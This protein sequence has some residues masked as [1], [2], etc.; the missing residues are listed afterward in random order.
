MIQGFFLDN[1]TDNIAVQVI[2]FV[3][4]YLTKREAAQVRNAIKR[5]YSIVEME[6]EL[7]EEFLVYDNDFGLWNLERRI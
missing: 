3:G 2:D 6:D 7:F 1:E 5:R 4:L